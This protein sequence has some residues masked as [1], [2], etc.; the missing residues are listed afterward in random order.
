MQRRELQEALNLKHEDHFRNAYLVPV[1][2]PNLTEM[3]TPDKP[4]GGKQKYRLSDKGAGG[5]W[6][7]TAAPNESRTGRQGPPPE[8][9][10]RG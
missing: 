2:D 7:D 8:V 6:T 10:H 9:R 1:L 3:T 5:G 4:R